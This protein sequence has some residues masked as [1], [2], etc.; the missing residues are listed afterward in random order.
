MITPGAHG[1]ARRGIGRGVFTLILV[2]DSLMNLSIT[3]EAFSRWVVT[4]IIRVKALEKVV[5]A[6]EEL[7]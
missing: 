4:L 5:A 7:E 2:G 1:D 3:H 6:V